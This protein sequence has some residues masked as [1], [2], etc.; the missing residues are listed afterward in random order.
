MP[1]QI[2]SLFQQKKPIIGCVHLKA[3]PGSPQ[4]DGNNNAI[5]E[6]AL[7]EARIY[8]EK[9]VDA[10]IIE[11]F[12]D[13]PFYPDEVPSITVA[14]MAAIGREIKLQTQLPIGINVLR[15]DSQAALSIA[16]AINAQ[17][18][19]VNIHLYAFVSDQGIIQGL[20]HETLRL[21]KSLSTDIQIWTDVAVKHA[22]PL[23][24]Q[25]IQIQAE[26]LC[27]RGLADVLIVSGIGTGKA[28][29]KQALVLVK[30]PASI[31]VVIGSGITLNN[32]ADYYTIADGFIIGS[33]FKEK[34]L[35][36]NALDPKRISELVTFTQQ[37]NKNFYK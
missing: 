26:E 37:L 19:R 20:A 22:S 36:Q 8:Q 13:K 11:N 10:I 1:I 2:K 27:E 5:L 9:G 35:S 31:P 33:Y 34:G 32:I 21:R 28:T 23:V 17:F 6:Q 3:L 18:I 16:H 4:Y 29:D 12:G 25:S 14:T 24:N 30:E 15:N 7:T